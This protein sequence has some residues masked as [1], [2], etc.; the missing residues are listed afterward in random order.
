[1]EIITSTIITAH[2][3][4]A[5]DALER[6]RIADAAARANPSWLLPDGLAVEWTGTS[7]SISGKAFGFPV[8]G[9]IVASDTDVRITLHVPWTAKALVANFSPVLQSHLAHVLSSDATNR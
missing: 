8:T 5:Q 9:E 1:M 2:D 4:D 6:L 3:L 7:G